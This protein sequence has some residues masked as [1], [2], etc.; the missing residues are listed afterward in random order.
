MKSYCRDWNRK[1]LVTPFFFTLGGV[2]GV[3]N[4]TAQA[5][6]LDWSGQFRAESHWVRNYSLDSSNIMTDGTRTASGGYYIPG[7][8]A[9]T[10]SFQTLFMR[11][12]PKVVVN[13]NVYLKTEWWLSDP[14]FGIFGNASPYTTDQKQYYSTQSR[15]SA[16]TAQ[17][18]WAEFMSD[19]GTFQV[20]RIP[21]HY[22][23]GIIWN[24]GEGIWDRYE[25][26]G[27]AIRLVS[28]FGA[29]HFIPGI[30]KYST[31]NTIGGACNFAGGTCTPVT[32][33]ASVMDY[34]LIFKYENPDEDFEGGVN[35]IKRIAGAAQDPTAGYLGVG[36]IAAAPAPVGMHF[37]TWDLYGKKKFSSFTL[38]GEIPITSG[39]IGSLEYKTFAVALEG[40]WKISDAWETTIRAG[41]A[42]GQPNSTSGTA[43]KYRAFYF[44]PNYHLG[45]VMFNYQLAGLA[46]LQSLN[47]SAATTENLTSPFNNP[48]VNGNS[49]DIKVSTLYARKYNVL[50][51]SLT[52]L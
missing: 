39:T 14:V 45:L 31:G 19:A 11:L 37:N 15:G 21:L 20:G 36:S 4:F 47:N 34:S 38:S 41:Q 1:L 46:G 25:S 27:D 28:K 7:G 50:H 29:F 10:A 18:F 35:F 30:I 5:L 2:I 24:S 8:G 13:D 51:P 12:R 9:S 3:L 49:F 44:N 22:G 26:T 23:L 16:I 40:N 48:I 6:D 43:D 17:R 32:G 42:P 33:G 52:S